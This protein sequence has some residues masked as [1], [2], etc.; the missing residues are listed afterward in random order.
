[1]AQRLG[2]VPADGSVNKGP[3]NWPTKP[4]GGRPSSAL[5]R[6]PMPLVT[7]LRD[8]SNIGTIGMGVPQQQ[9]C[10]RYFLLSTIASIQVSRE[11]LSRTGIN[12]VHQTPPSNRVP[13]PIPVPVPVPV[14]VLSKPD[15]LH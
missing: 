11:T 4:C 3:I 7:A 12:P 6:L 10:K 9:R 5:G 13:V 15:M 2:A 1:M 14:P 8:E